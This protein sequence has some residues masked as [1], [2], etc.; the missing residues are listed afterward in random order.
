[1]KLDK[2]I[3]IDDDYA[4]NYYNKFIIEELNC[5]NEIKVIND[6]VIAMSYLQ[7][8]DKNL[9]HSTGISIIFLDINL[10]KYSGF[11]IMDKIEGTFLSLQ[12]KNVHTFLL[13][14]SDNPYDKIKSEKYSYVE[15]YCKPLEQKH[16]KD[17]YNQIIKS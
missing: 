10:P 8:L 4:S 14:T 2:V 15:Y 13:T 16:L 11:E 7:E 17:I 9:Q 6:A 3:L 12:K 1:M 5:T